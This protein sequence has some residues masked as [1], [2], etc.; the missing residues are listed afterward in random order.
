MFQD[1]VSDAEPK[2]DEAVVD[3]VLIITTSRQNP[4]LMLPWEKEP[5]KTKT[6]KDWEKEG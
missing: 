5:Q 1:K 4:R 3:M 6:V 2:K